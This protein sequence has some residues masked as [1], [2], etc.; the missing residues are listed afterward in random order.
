MEE[1]TAAFLRQ[2]TESYRQ[3]QNDEGG[4]PFLNGRGGHSVAFGIIV[5]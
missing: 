2:V 1:F 5:L 4:K 3:I